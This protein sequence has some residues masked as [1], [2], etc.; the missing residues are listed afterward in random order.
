MPHIRI[1]MHRSHAPRMTEISTALHNSL[2][3]GLDM[4]ADD[5]FQIIHLHDAGELV[6]SRSFPEAE[7]DD[8]I[9]IQVL[10]SLGYS[11]ELKQRMYR[12]MV[13]NMVALGIPQDVLLI[14]IVEIDGEHNWHSPAKASAA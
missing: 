14:S 1:D 5:L 6:F 11:P 4:P 2:V 13:E 7:R 8:I 9:F 10:A 3:E 12:S